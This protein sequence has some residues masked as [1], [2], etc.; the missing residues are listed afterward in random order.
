M[1]RH[2]LARHLD[3]DRVRAAIGAAESQTTG[4]I[5]VTLSHRF[6]GTT[7]AGAMRAFERLRLAHT[8][9]RNGVLFFVVPARREFAVVG[10]VGI[11]EKVGQEF[12][13]RIVSVT[14]AR[15]KAGDL[16]DGLVHGIEEA[17]L[18][19]AAHYPRP[20]V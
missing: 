17:G 3:E 15:I 10:D 5:H 2:R 8:P 6:L 1:R 12:W 18:E 20:E 14:S 4:R 13:D 11:H 16:T 19:L 9:D 7:F